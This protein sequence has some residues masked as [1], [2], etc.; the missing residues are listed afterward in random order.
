MDPTRDNRL[1]ACHGPTNTVESTFLK[2][3]AGWREIKPEFD[4][5]TSVFRPDQRRRARKALK[6]S[7][8]DCEAAVLCPGSDVFHWSG[9]T[10]AATFV[11]YGLEALLCARQRRPKAADFGMDSAH[12]RVGDSDLGQSEGDVVDV[13][14][15]PGGDLDQL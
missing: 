1:A 15:D 13:A 4:R 14:H 5:W 7:G 11:Q 8:T 2:W 12:H 3:R 9:Q 6:Q 10:C